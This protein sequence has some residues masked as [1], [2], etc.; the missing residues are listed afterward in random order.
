MSF[1]N[2]V[3]A[4]TIYSLSALHSFER[5]PSLEPC[6]DVLVRV[7]LSKFFRSAIAIIGEVVEPGSDDKIRDCELLS[8][9][10]SFVLQVTIQ[11]IEQALH[12]HDTA[13]DGILNVHRRVCEKMAKHATKIGSRTLQPEDP[14]EDFCTGETKQ[15]DK[16]TQHRTRLTN[17][18][19]AHEG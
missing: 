9:Q 15:S 17:L 12:F 4:E 5:V 3:F 10:P 14:V 13:I 8:D 16:M 1:R 6:V 2:S 18:F 19:D 11:H 7:K